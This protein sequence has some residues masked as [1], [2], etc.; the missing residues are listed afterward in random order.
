M[1]AHRITLVAL[2][3]D[4][5]RGVFGAAKQIHLL[6]RQL[7]IDGEHLMGQA[8]DRGIIQTIV[9]FG[10]HTASFLRSKVNK[11][12][13]PMPISHCALGSVRCKRTLVATCASTDG[14]NEPYCWRVSVSITLVVH[15]GCNIAIVPEALP[16]LSCGTTAGGWWAQRIS[17]SDKRLPYN[18][19]VSFTARSPRPGAGSGAQFTLLRDS[20]RRQCRHRPRR[21]FAVLVWRAGPPD[22]GDTF[23]TPN[24]GEPALREALANALS[25]LHRPV[26]PDRVVV[27]TPVWPNLVEIPRILGA[28]VEEVA[29]E[30]QRDEQGIARWHLLSGNFVTRLNA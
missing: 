1:E 8:D 6:R 19:R 9:L 13:N 27:V 15:C 20:R 2:V 18:V 7:G 21:C 11:H 14:G 3:N 4:A 12:A 23:Y 30:L 17:L 24:L 5:Q 26:S 29:L 25:Q 28:Q 16:R 22:A 10:S